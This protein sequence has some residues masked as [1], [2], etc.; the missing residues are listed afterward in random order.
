MKYLWLLAFWTL[1]PLSWA[2]E[3]DRFNE[4]LVQKFQQDIQ[5]HNDF[6]LKSQQG[7]MRAP[8][9]V[10]GQEEQNAGPEKEL[11][12]VEKLKQVG[13]KDW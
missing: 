2:H 1:T 7:R 3:A 6:S 12:K 11:S 10:V 5:N 13:A 9:S 8:A 4:V